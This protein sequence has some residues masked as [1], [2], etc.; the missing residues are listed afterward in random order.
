MIFTCYSLYIEKIKG[1]PMKKLSLI[2]AL[3]FAF[4]TLQAET[5]VGTFNGKLRGSD[6]RDAHTLDLH[7][8]DYRYALELTGD[9]GVKVRLRVTKNQWTGVPVTLIDAKKLESRHTHNGNFTIEVRGAVGQPTNGTRETKFI[10]T[11]KVG[12]R[13]VNYTL[14]IYKK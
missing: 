6:T 11:K 9:K 13:Q 5:L 12:P 7:K 4:T 14:K 10:V 2:V 3:L 1:F 8:G